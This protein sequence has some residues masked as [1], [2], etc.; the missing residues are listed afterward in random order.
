[1]STTQHIMALPTGKTS[2]RNLMKLLAQSLLKRVGLYQRLKSSRVYDWFWGYVNRQLID[3]RSDEIE[4]YRQTLKGFRRGDVVF[5]VGANQGYKTDMF[6]RLGAKVVAIDPDEANQEVLRQ[7]FI[8]LR[9][10]PKP[11]TIVGKAVSDSIAVKTLWIDAPGSAKNTLS[12]K[13]VE[14][15]RKDEKHFGERLDFSNR[16]E[17]ET[18]TL[19]QL[20]TTYG[21][22]FFVKIDVEGYEAN[23]I[24]GLNCPVPFLSFEVNLPEFRLDALECIKS[25]CLI[26]PEG[27]FNYVTDCREGLVLKQWLSHK[28]FARAFEAC[29]E[30]SI[31][32]FWRT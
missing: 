31:E 9:F 11:V 15:L 24:R 28:E 8:T 4:F 25:L 20:I 16:K 21:V 6:L 32:V 27:E 7:R 30:P 14:T 22:P 26:A 17:V 23:V 2:E 13:W 10:V 3:D 18:T 19:Q 1:M 12:L 5:D 29:A